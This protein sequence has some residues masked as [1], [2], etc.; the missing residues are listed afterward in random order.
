MSNN[1]LQMDWLSFSVKSNYSKGLRHKKEK[2]QVLNLRLSDGSGNRT[3]DSAV[4]GLR[5]NRLTNP[6]YYQAAFYAT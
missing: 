3:R 1:V 5:L 2:P 6:P 4:R